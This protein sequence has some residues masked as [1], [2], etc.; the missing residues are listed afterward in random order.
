M[1]MILLLHTIRI[2]MGTDVL[3][4][5]RVLKMLKILTLFNSMCTMENTVVDQPYT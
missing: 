5:M 3:G 4:C 1:Y 2:M